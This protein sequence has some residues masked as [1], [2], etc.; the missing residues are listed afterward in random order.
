MAEITISISEERLEQLR[1]IAIEVGTS[2]EDLA[3]ASL[4]GWLRQ[5]R[6][7][8]TEAAQRVLQKNP[9]LYRRLA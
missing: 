2:A 8:F 1:R 9:E 6:E 3:R 4:E 5:P 7:G